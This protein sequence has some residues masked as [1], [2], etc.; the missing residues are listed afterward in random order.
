MQMVNT[1][2][3]NTNYV[4]IINFLE[5]KLKSLFKKINIHLCLLCSLPM[6]QLIEKRTK[7]HYQQQNKQVC[8]KCPIHCVC[9]FQTLKCSLYSRRAQPVSPHMF[10]LYLD[11]QFPHVPQTWLC[12]NVLHFSLNPGPALRMCDTYIRR[13]S[14]RRSPCLLK[15][16]LLLF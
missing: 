3:H 10:H 6:K 8:D 16:Q 11:Y 14:F 15:I 9:N 5:K 2:K 4:C 13:G 1:D 12:G 7:K